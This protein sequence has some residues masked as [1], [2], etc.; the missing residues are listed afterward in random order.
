VTPRHGPKPVMGSFTDLWGERQASDY[1]LEDAVGKAETTDYFVEPQQ[2]QDAAATAAGVCYNEQQ[3][4][5]Q[6]HHFTNYYSS[7]HYPQQQQQLYVHA[8]KIVAH[9]PYSLVTPVKDV[10]TCGCDSC[11]GQYRNNTHNNN[12]NCTMEVSTS[13]NSESYQ[14][15]SYQEETPSPTESSQAA[16]VSNSIVALVSMPSTCLDHMSEEEMSVILARFMPPPP[17]RV[18]TIDIL[19]ACG[20]PEADVVVYHLMMRWFAKATAGQSYFI[21]REEDFCPAPKPA[22]YGFVEWCDKVSQ[23]WF[24]HFEHL[25]KRP[26]RFRAAW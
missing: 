1:I 9:D 13:S 25:Q 3:P 4:T 12:G 10:F 24:K 5:E 21:S 11:I 20:T 6:A 8:K 19:T 17:P 18:D 7:Q 23:W 26:S 2:Q 14:A 16:A 15:L 22:E